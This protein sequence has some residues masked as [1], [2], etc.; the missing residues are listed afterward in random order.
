MPQLETLATD[1]THAHYAYGRLLIHI[2]WGRMGADSVALAA[3]LGRKLAGRHPRGTG[4][5]TIACQGLPIPDREA[6]RIGSE[7]MV[8]SQAWLQCNGVVLTGTGFWASAARACYS[9]MQFVVR[10]RSPQ[11]VFADVDEGVAWCCSHLDELA[12]HASRIVAALRANC[13]QIG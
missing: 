8:E 13:P 5:I 7:A 3:E 9:A 12:P 10:H 2:W 11:K 6:Q 1:D 4:S